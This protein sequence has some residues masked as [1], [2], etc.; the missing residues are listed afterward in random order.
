MVI[1]FN[2]FTRYFFYLFVCYQYANYHYPEKTQ[3]AVIFICYNSVYLYSKLQIFVNKK[4]IEGNN[5][6]I[7]YEEYKNLLNF[8]NVMK[9]RFDMLISS[10][11]SSKQITTH[12]ID[13]VT[14]DFVLNN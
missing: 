8:L 10:Y 4:L 13:K 1:D 9:H 11:T 7:K 2:T 12:K 14:L 3:E 6:L 5:Y